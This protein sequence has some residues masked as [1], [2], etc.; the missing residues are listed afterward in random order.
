MFNIY[1]DEKKKV[2]SCTHIAATSSGGC[3][4]A[5]GGFLFWFCFCF[6]VLGFELNSGPCSC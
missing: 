5:C 4:F 3:V 6:A 1:F 2:L